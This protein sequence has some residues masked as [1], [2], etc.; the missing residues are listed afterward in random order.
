MCVYIYIYVYTSLSLS[1]YIYIYIYPAL[2]S[3]EFRA[4]DLREMGLESKSRG[5]AS[6]SKRPRKIQGSQGLDPFWQIECL[7]ADRVNAFYA[8]G[9][10]C[11]LKDVLG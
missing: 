8:Q 10:R 7:K 9:S 11:M 5:L 4:R 1:I 3:R 6:T 2:S